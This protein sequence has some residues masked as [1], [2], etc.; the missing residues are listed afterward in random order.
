MM[1]IPKIIKKISVNEKELKVLNALRDKTFAARQQTHDDLFPPF[2]DGL[3]QIRELT[4]NIAL[5]SGAIAAFTIPVVPTDF[6]QTKILAYLS[7][8]LLFTTISYAVFH[9][10]QVITKEVNQLSKQNSLFEKIYDD[11]IDRI[12]S[13]IESGD[14]KILEIDQQSLIKELSSLEEISN[15]DKSL[16]YLRTLL[17]LALFLLVLSFIPTHFY[18]QILFAFHF[19]R[20]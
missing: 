6:I 3:R 4:Q 15:P 19:L 11:H 14:K 17:I 13:V 2:A 1:R 20:I 5:I 8:I 16:I 9:L 10:S 12:N 7:L 18:E